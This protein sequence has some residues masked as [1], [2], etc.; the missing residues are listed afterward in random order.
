MKEDAN[1]FMV[2]DELNESEEDAT[3]VWSTTTYGAAE[4]Y[5]DDDVDGQSDG[6]YARGQAICV[7]NHAGELFTFVVT[8]DYS[9]TH[10][11]RLRQE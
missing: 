7:R 3:E 6:I 4:R 1:T 8:A 9:V 10:S 11:A 5:A 2:W